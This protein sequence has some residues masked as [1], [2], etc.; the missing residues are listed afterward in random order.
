MGVRKF[1]N[2]GQGCP[3]TASSFETQDVLEESINNS[4]F[5]ERTI[6]A[7]T[8]AFRKRLL[9]AGAG[10]GTGVRSR[11]RFAGSM[12]VEGDSMSLLF[13][14]DPNLAKTVESKSR[15]PEMETFRVSI[16]SLSQAHWAFSPVPLTSSYRFGL[17]TTLW[18][19]RI[20]ARPDSCRRTRDQK[21]ILVHLISAAE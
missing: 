20:H 8:V 1:W 19:P 6:G 4:Q 2:A 11:G 9:F 5:P 13:K 15:M 3:T 12:D 21:S 10:H 18:R 14:K 16:P 17:D 7:S